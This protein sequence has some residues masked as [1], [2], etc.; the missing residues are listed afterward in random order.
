MLAVIAN[1]ISTTHEFVTFNMQ[2]MS[3]HRVWHVVAAG[4]IMSE[5][6]AKKLVDLE[7]SMLTSFHQCIEDDKEATPSKKAVMKKVQAGSAFNMKG[8]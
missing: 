4:F 3:E 7:R 5:G 8:S 6:A 1:Q 2:Q